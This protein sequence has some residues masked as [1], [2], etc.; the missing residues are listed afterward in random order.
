MTCEVTYKN[1]VGPNGP[2]GAT[3]VARTEPIP[4]GV[5]GAD[6]TISVRS[7]LPTDFSSCLSV[8]F[9]RSLLQQVQLDYLNLDYDSTIARLDWL[10]F[11]IGQA[12]QAEPPLDSDARQSYEN[13]YR[14]AFSLRESLRLGLDAFGLPQN[15]V[16]LLT[17]D[18]YL[19]Q[20]DKMIGYGNDIQTAYNAV[21]QNL[22]AT[23]ASADNYRAVAT[24]LVNAIGLAQGQIS[25]VQSNI[26]S[27]QNVIA[28]MREDMDRLLFE[29]IEA[30]REFKSALNRQSGG[31][32]ILQLVQFVAA[33]VAVVYTAGAAAGAVAGAAGALA[34]APTDPKGVPTQ[35]TIQA[36]QYYVRTL[37]PAGKSLEEFQTAF[38][39]L[40]SSLDTKAPN[41]DPTLPPDDT[42]LLVEKA[43]FDKQIQPFLNLPE[44]QKYKSLMDTYVT[45]AQT[46]NNKIVELNSLYLQMA[47]LQSD[48]ADDNAQI[49]STSHLISGT[50]DPRIPDLNVFFNGALRSVKLQIASLIYFTRKA[51]QFYTAKSASLNVVYGGLSTPTG[52]NASQTLVIRDDTV[53]AL[54][55]ALAL[56]RSDMDSAMQASAR[57]PASF[58]QKKISLN[59]YLTASNLKSLRESG[60]FSFQIPFDAAEFNHYSR[61]LVKRI[62]FEFD[63]LSRKSISIDILQN[64]NS[65]IRDDSGKRVDFSHL[66]VRSRVEIGGD[67][68]AVDDG[69]IVDA[70]SPYSGVSPFGL[71]TINVTV[72]NPSLLKNITQVHVVLSG[73]YFPI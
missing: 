41:G 1:V 72:P 62:D 18:F 23:T 58:A 14:S 51:Y 53:Q 24:A 66:P 45:T 54:E 8:S 29:L 25:N 36:F 32:N 26:T 7:I 12:L 3:G 28:S 2:V 13:L 68:V 47:K 52:V 70:K 55:S 71:W 64:G 27:L 46:R 35:D 6:G 73:V 21:Y 11:S 48:I 65:P 37:Q 69:T 57:A 19:G 22:K 10:L 16:P 31:C 43:D 33:V 17:V 59:P 44:A 63:G 20:I 61:T 38:N 40:K 34:K 30:D 50:F 15:Y 67:G 60:T 5:S 39:K 42:K 9:A 56:L 49:G 4:A